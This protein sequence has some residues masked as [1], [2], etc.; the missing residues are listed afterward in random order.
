MRFARIGLK[1]ALLLALPVI[2]WADTHIDSLLEMKENVRQKSQIYDTSILPDSLIGD[3]CNEAVVWTSTDVGGV[4]SRV[5]IITVANTAFYALPD[6][7]VEVLFQTLKSG[8]FTRSVKAMPPQFTEELNIATSLTDGT[9]DEFETPVAF[10]FWDDTLQLIPVPEKV[11]TLWFY[12]YV[13]HPVMTDTVNLQFT[14]SAYAT[15]AMYWAVAEVLSLV[16][17]DERAAIWEARYEKAATKLRERF[18]RKF[19]L[20]T[21]LN[22]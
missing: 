7:V 8:D 10:I 15:A 13:E 2:G 17:E 9:T 14:H 20:L 16:G 5:R 21:E 18:R 1:V 3:I 4:E 22:K 19:D 12:C 11:D 6:T